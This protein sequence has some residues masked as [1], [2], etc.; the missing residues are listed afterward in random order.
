LEPGAKSVNDRLRSCL[1]SPKAYSEENVAYLRG[2]EPPTFESGVQLFGRSL[3]VIV[4]D[5]FLLFLSASSVLVPHLCHVGGQ[6]WAIRGKRRQ[7]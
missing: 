6:M 3:C 1:T 4:D 7:S 2:F 5:N